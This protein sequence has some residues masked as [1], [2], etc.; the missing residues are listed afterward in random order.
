MSGY[1]V[2]ACNTAHGSENKIHGDAVVWG[3]A[4]CRDREQSRHARR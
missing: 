4:E 3:L 1:R 2:Q